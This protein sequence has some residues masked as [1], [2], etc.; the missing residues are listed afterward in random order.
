MKTK[1]L[2]LAAIAAM[3]SGIASAHVLEVGQP[4]PTA[5]VGEGGIAT[6][7]DGEVEFQE[8]STD[9]LKD[10]IILAMAGRPV[11]SK[12]A[13]DE[14]KAKLNAAGVYTVINS[15]DAPFGAGMFITGSIKEGKLA[16]PSLNSVKD[17]DGELFAEWELATESL[18]LIAVKDGKVVFVQEG[19]ITDAEGE[20]AISM[21]K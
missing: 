3:T 5:I 14:L 4:L 10:G 16:T 1:L 18:A 20:K 8:W 2:T 9:T 12:M 17:D 11:S 15:D 19:N 6:I 21:I 13:S 7:V